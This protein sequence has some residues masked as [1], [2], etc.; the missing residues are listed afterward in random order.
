MWPPDFCSQEAWK[1]SHVLSRLTGGMGQACSPQTTQPGRAPQA[2]GDLTSLT[3]MGFSTPA[4]LL[5]PLPPVDPCP[6]ITW[7]L[8]STFYPV[9]LRN[10]SLGQHLAGWLHSVHRRSPFVCMACRMCAHAQLYTV[11]PDS[12]ATVVTSVGWLALTT[13][14]PSRSEPRRSFLLVLSLIPGEEALCLPIETCFSIP[15]VHPA[16]SHRAP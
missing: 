3:S 13:T 2:N 5:P 14:W 6:S 8:R 15:R 7:Y 10:S 16:A 9:K 1:Q 4:F 11:F 12:E